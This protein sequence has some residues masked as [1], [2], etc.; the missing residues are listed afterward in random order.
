MI[1]KAT[2]ESRL[3]FTLDHLPRGLPMTVSYARIQAYLDAIAAQANGDVTASPHGEFWHVDYAAF[4]AGNVP[5]VQCQGHPIPD[6]AA[7]HLVNSAF[8]R[9]LTDGTGFCGMEQM[10]AG[11]PFIT[12][13][14]LQL[15]LADGTQ[16]TGAQ[17]QADIHDWL[18]NGA[19][20]A[21]A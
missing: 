19:P 1:A 2:R 10:P 9:I 11:G 5:G 8:Y 12:D 7:G 17:V 6:L 4:V 20:E 18:A 3:S 21:G 14:G 13:P 16:I 15:V